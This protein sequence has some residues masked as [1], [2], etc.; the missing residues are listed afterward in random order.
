M[1]TR[2]LEVDGRSLTLEALDAVAHGRRSVSPELPETARRRMEESRAVVEEILSGDESVYGVN[3]GFGRLSEVRVPDDRLEE[4][5]RNL[6]RSHACG[7]GEPLSPAEARAMILVRANSLAVGLSGVRPRVVEALLGLL[8][9]GVIPVIPREGSVG[10]SGDLAPAAHLGL[11][12]MGEGEAWLDGERM[13]GGEALARGGLEPLV[14]GPKEGL[15]LLNGTQAMTAVGGLALWR[16]ERLA[17]V[18]DVAGALSLEGLKGTPVPFDEAVQRSRPHRG[19]AESAGFLRELLEESEIRESHRHGDPRVQD[20]YSLRC[21]PQVHGAARDRLREVREVLTTELN[22]A[23]DNP[24]VFPDRP[25]GQRVVSQGNFH[26]QPVASALDSLATAVCTLAVISERRIDRLLNPDLS[27]LP[28]F[29]T[30]EPGL[31]SGFMMAQVTAASQVAECRSLAA[32]DS[33]GSIPTGAAK[34]DHVSM[35]MHAADHAAAA[36][37]R[38]ARVLAV[39][40][41]AGAQAVEFHRPLRA[42]SGVV[43]ALASIRETVPRLEEDRALSGDL[44]RV[45]E[46]LDAGGLDGLLRRKGGGPW[47]GPTEDRGRQA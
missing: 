34:E 20:A 32:P 13:D 41:L 28:A 19:Q 40:L 16:A 7:V 11:V 35:G 26:G 12:L 10:A 15:S 5:Q 46:W 3:T 18:A 1:S 22:S 47:S 44:G 37:E 2:P 45:V 29:L 6:I 39:E 25:S 4:L 43:E 14:L 42:G 9:A 21:M 24:L 27:G 30:P 31:R 38:A 23:T 33:V 17:R 8:D 36:V